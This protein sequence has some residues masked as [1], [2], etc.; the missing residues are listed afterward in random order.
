MSGIATAIAATAVLG[1]AGASKQSSAAQNSAQM[2]AD[3][4][5]RAQEQQQAN[6]KLINEQQAPGRAVGYSALNSLGSMLPGQNQQY[7]AQGNPTG[8]TTGSGYLTQTFGPD[9]LKSNLAPNYDF[10]L[11]QGL[12]AQN[13]AMN[14][15]GG[16]SNV[17][18]AGTK[19][20]EDYAS[21]AYQNAFN[22]FQ[23]QQGNIYNRLAGIAGLGQAA[24]NQ[25]NQ[26]STNATNA[27]G[28]LGVG[29]AGALG[30]GQIGSANAMAGGLQGIGNA[31][32]LASLMQP[33]WS[34]TTP[35][36][37]TG[38]QTPYTAPTYPTS[39]PGLGSGMFGV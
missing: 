34:A 6:F 25:T 28:Q 11:K 20:A 2:Q 5:A 15:G 39:S 26:A 38:F 30:S 14:V 18:I 31:G 21:N 27:I 23:T 19:F 37:M 17:G 35:T 32:Y 12:G 10:M 13:Q 4:A 22:N 7:D 8:M 1:Y 29:A 16:G 33:S 24:Q 9:Q 3:A 36:D